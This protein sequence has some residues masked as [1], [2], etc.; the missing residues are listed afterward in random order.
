MIPPHST[1][2]HTKT[3]M[4][5]KIRRGRNCVFHLSSFFISRHFLSAV[6]RIH[7]LVDS[8]GSQISNLEC[9]FV[10]HL[11]DGESIILQWWRAW[12]SSEE[13][14]ILIDK[15]KRLNSTELGFK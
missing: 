8:I 3:A 15:E 5:T 2:A 13:S 9:G 12:W 4:N 7:F 6:S 10:D 1:T 11:V 14:A